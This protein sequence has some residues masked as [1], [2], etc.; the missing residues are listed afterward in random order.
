ACDRRVIGRRLGG[1]RRWRRWCAGAALDAPSRRGGCRHRHRHGERSLTHCS[2][3]IQAR[4]A[5]VALG[6]GLLLASAPSAGAQQPEPYRDPPLACAVIDYGSDPP[7]IPGPT[8]DPLCVRYD[9]TNAT[10]SDLQALDF[11]AA[12]PGRI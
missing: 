3:R 1:G 7:P 10:V 5:M 4:L 9:K 6:A 2:L 8:D 11:L 12:E